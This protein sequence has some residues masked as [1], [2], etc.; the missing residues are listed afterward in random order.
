MNLWLVNQYATPPTVAGPARHHAFAK[1]LVKRG[2]QVEI[3]AGSVCHCSTDQLAVGPGTY[4][5]VEEDGIDYLRIRVPGYRGRSAARVLDMFTFAWRLRRADSRAHLDRPDVILGSTLHPFGAYAAQRLAQRLQV[6][7]V[8]E[9]RDL[10]PQTLL[11]LGKISRWHPFVVLLGLI[12]R[13]L[14]RHSHHIV[15]LLP[16]AGEYIHLKGGDPRRITWIP[17]GVDFST[18]PAPSPPKDGEPF[19]CA[20]TGSIGLA[21]G[22]D[23][24]I[25]AAAKLKQDGWEKRIQFRI[26]GYG[27]DKTRLMEWVKSA[28]LLNVTFEPMVPK[29]EVFGILQASHALFLNVL[30]SPLYRWGYSMNKLFDYLAAARPILIV[31]SA[32][33]NP[34]KEAQGGITC[35]LHDPGAVADALKS[36]ATMDPARRWEL[37][38]NGHSFCRKHHSFEVLTN[39][40]EAIAKNLVADRQRE[41]KLAA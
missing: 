6:P 40:L 30:D 32:A 25:A 24:L 2:H 9:V 39:R 28:G 23:L 1:E 29:A 16:Y 15:T 8:F 3:I 31:T 20:Y 12:E 14:Y 10:W 38:L 41:Q 13:Y 36:L 18:V 19:I 35:G 11:D 33:Y 5:A 27:T 22:L 26:Y 21:N 34:V 37:G 17:N 4:T 7:Y